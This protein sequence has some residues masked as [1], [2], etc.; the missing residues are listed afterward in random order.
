MSQM[1]T[2]NVVSGFRFESIEEAEIARQEKQRVALL[3]EKLDYD[4]IASIAMIYEKAVTNSVFTTPIGLSFLLKLQQYLIEKERPE[5]LLMIPVVHPQDEIVT[6]SDR[7]EEILAKEDEVEAKRLT[8][9]V[10]NLKKQLK[11]KDKTIQ[12]M[13]L[14]MRTSLIVNTVLVFVV[15]ALFVI[16]YLGE[17]ANVINYKRVLTDR[18]ASWEEEL[19]TREEAIRI[20]EKELQIESWDTQN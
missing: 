1:D 18:Y 10:E 2:D 12:G 6:D 5:G 17:N 9:R 7:V 20:K 3:E 16:T 13:K 19:K 8:A 11:N 15:I 14:T 4:N